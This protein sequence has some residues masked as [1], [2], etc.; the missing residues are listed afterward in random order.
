MR[1]GRLLPA[2]TAFAAAA[3][4]LMVLAGSGAAA[5]GAG[6]AQ[7]AWTVAKAKSYMRS[8]GINPRSIVVQSG[9]RNYAG[10]RCPGKNW[11]C[12]RAKHVIQISR[13]FTSV[14]ANKFTCKGASAGTDAGTN[15]CVVVQIGT[16]ADNDAR[17]FLTDQVSKES[18]TSQ[19]CE[20]TQTNGTGRNFAWV[21]Q[22]LRQYDAASETANQHATVKQTNRAGNNEVMATQ[23]LIQSSVFTAATLT[24]MQEARQAVGVDQHSGTG[25]N[26]SEIHQSLQLRAVVFSGQ[27]AISQSQNITDAG[28]NTLAE[29]SQISDSGGRNDSTLQ[30]YNRLEAQATSKKGPVVQKQ[31]S[32]SGGLHGDVHQDST[33]VSTT[34]SVQDEDQIAHATTPP[35]TLTQVQI[36]PLFCCGAGSSIGNGD[37]SVTISQTG[38][39]ESDGGSQTNI[40]EASCRSSGTCG[41]HQHKDNNVDSLTV[42]DSCE[43][44]VESPCIIDRVVECTDEGCETFTEG[45]EGSPDSSLS[46]AVRNVSRAESEYSTSTLITGGGQTIQY[47][48]SYLNDG[49][50]TAH[51]VRL[52]DTPPSSFDFGSCTGGCEII[53][54]GGT[55]AWNLGDV[56]AGESRTVTFTGAAS[57]V[58][59]SNTADGSSTE[60]E[61]F[62]SNAATTA[63]GCIN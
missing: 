38:H 57:C 43:G 48:L 49:N 52:F 47:R 62:S 19:T 16:T 60:E 24:Q 3:V 21:V 35:G 4:A 18:N 31:G 8:I 9:Q 50:G 59:T 54:E 17:C 51:D 33:G 29:V 6:L 15:K 46:K 34:S 45:G 12:T 20:I 41:T 32:L 42:D 56:P 40:A 44:S 61:G 39:Q 58:N 30:Q 23:T 7:P 28:P 37:N 1:F 11:N 2:L 22:D 14:I 63:D 25:S 55:L 5:N 53:S 10:P 13:S 36:G 26:T 27:G